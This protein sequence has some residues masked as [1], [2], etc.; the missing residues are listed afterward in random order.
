MLS[1]HGKIGEGSVA[2]AH[3]LG[4]DDNPRHGGTGDPSI[5]Y[6]V[7]PKSGLG[8]GKLRTAR[9]K[10][11]VGL[12]GVPAMG[13]RYAAQNL[14]HCALALLHQRQSTLFSQHDQIITAD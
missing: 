1:P 5:A 2:L 3:A 4:L 6:L 9:E 12:Q 7:F 11:T 8:P 14:F 13:R 10:S